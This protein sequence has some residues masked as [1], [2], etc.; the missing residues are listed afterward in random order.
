MPR[1]IGK[2][3]ESGDPASQET[4]LAPSSCSLPGCAGCS[5]V[6]RSGDKL[7][8]SC[9][10]Q[11]PFSIPRGA[12]SARRRKMKVFIFSSAALVALAA[13]SFAQSQLTYLHLDDENVVVSATRVP[14]PLDQVASSVT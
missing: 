6:N 8:S 9:G 12:S 13:P 2:T 3:D 1:G 11:N 14:T 7:E 10:G 5:G 4:C